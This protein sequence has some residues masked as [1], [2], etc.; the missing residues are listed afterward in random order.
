MAVM[1]ANTGPRERELRGVRA[2][3]LEIFVGHTCVV[4]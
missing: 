3:S 1:A 2:V 4:H